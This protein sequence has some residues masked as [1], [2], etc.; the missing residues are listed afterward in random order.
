MVG[1]AARQPHV[2]YEDK[3]IPLPF[4]PFPPPIKFLPY[5]ATELTETQMNDIGEL[6]KAYVISSQESINRIII[7]EK[8][9]NMYSELAEK[10]QK[11]LEALDA[12]GKNVD[13]SLLEQMNIEINKTLQALSTEINT[14][15]EKHSTQMLQSLKQMD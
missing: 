14:Q 9:Y 10:S 5:Y 15:N 12:M 11:R 2:V 8:I 13:H 1:C 6:S 4:V 7:L 3:Y